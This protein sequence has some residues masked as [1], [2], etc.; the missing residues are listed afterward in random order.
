MNW[1]FDLE[2]TRVLFTAVFKS[3]EDGS[4]REFVIHEKRDDFEELI[5]FLKDCKLLIGFNSYDF[6]GRVLEFIL[7]E[8]LPKRPRNKAMAIYRKAQEI[9]EAER[10]SW[11]TPTI[12][13]MD[14]FRIHH[15][16]NPARQTSLKW[17]AIN[18]R[19]DNVLD[20]PISHSEEIDASLIPLVLEYNRNDVE[21][22]YELWKRSQSKI[23]M[24]ETLS[25]KYG[26]DMTNF[27]DTKIG[28]T[29]V[30]K[31][32][33]E[34][35]NTPMTALKKCRTYHKE[36]R[37]RDA[38]LPTISFKTPEFQSIHEKFKQMVVTDT[39]PGSDL[40]VE[41]DDVPYYFGM[42][43]IHA[44]R[45]N[46]V[47]RSVNSCDVTGYYPSL[48]VSQG[49]YPKQF[50]KEFIEVY[51]EIAKERKQYVKGTDENIALKLA[52][53]GVFGKSNS[54]YSPFFD[55]MFFAKI[56]VNGQ[57]LLAM[58]CERLTIMGAAKIIMANTDG[59]ECTVLDKEKFDSIC[60]AWE[61]K[62]GLSLEHNKFKMMVVRDINNF[63]AVP[64]SGKIKLKGE[65]KTVEAMIS[66]GELH[67][68]FSMDIVKQAVIK[69]FTEGTPVE[70]TI[71]NCT[72]EYAF[73]IGERA[74][75][76]KFILRKVVNSEVRDEPLSKHLRFYIGTLGES[77]FKVATKTSA[78]YKGYK[79]M[80]RNQMKEITNVNKAFYKK[81]CQKL[82]DSIL[83]K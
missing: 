41:F 16:D 82:I 73:L 28:E 25:A 74:K 37:I 52:Q 3:T 4:I 13:Q 80:M 2:T 61:A 56:T 76:G 46:A 71:D 10:S 26:V 24:R 66:D 6:D 40:M 7:H 60:R 63:V 75:T 43:G 45:G 5:L 48:A 23:K 58:L 32:L 30:L 34:K 17:L 42:G 55:S 20:M 77:L 69:Y 70:Y 83:S 68:N 21:V 36:L 39:R 38:I 54:E 59:I 35:L 22:T 1:I 50:G 27:P 31:K 67:K 18:M 47:Y 65:F 29:I 15:F 78:V 72:D 81:E 64:E 8:K 53:N 11:Y 33:S 44:C 62:F 49:F 9:I 51:A 12:P 57:L 14:L 79:V 19:M